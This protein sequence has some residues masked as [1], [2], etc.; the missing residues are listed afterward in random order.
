[1][2]LQ[3]K[4]FLRPEV[5]LKKELL[6]KVVKK[7]LPHMSLK[8]YLMIFNMQCLAHLTQKK[9]HWRSTTIRKGRRC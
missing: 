8:K 3:T 6:K 2:L 1:M 9:R 5:L 7:L 4:N